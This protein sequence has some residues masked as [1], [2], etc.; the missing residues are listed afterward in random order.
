MFQIKTDLHTVHVRE[1]VARTVWVWTVI[2]EVRTA[3]GAT[4]TILECRGVA[5]S[6]E[7]AHAEMCWEEKL[8]ELKLTLLGF[9]PAR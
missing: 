7:A 9:E 8:T 2:V 4:P 1:Q 5:T 6:M 3:L